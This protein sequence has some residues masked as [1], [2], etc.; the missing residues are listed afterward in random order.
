MAREK[1]CPEC[2]KPGA[3]EYMNTYGDMM[4]L[5]VTFFV[6]LISFSSTEQNKFAMAMSSLRGSLGV[7][8]SARGKIVPVSNIP[9]FKLGRKDNEDQRKV[10]EAIKQLKDLTDRMGMRGMLTS[11]RDKDQIHFVIS[12]PLM[13]ETGSADLKKDSME[14]LILISKILS[15]F[16]YAIRIEG[17]TDNVPI[18]KPQF[19]SNWELSYA[20]GLAIAKLFQSEGIEPSRFQIIGFGEFQPIADN[21]TEQGKAINR[22]VEIFVNIKPEEKRNE[23]ISSGVQ[24]AVQ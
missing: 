14:P 4:T 15:F 22:R 2:P 19:P 5:L 18:S 21:K 23:I 12:E 10:E 8:Q 11:S 16:P 7:L 24:N 20:R 1:K 9:V 17:H 3:P 6:L 13:F